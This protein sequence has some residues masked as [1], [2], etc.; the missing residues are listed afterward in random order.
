MRCRGWIETDSETEWDYYWADVMWIR[1]NY[2][3]LRL[4]DRQRL[5]HFRNHYELTRKDVMVK[6]FK[7]MKK[8]IEK[9]GDVA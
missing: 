9:D 3:Y 2:D 8:A 4:D 7:K 1:E 5:N 6:N